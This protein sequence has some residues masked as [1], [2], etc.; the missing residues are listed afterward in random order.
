MIITARAKLIILINDT[1]VYNV[2]TV[3][4]SEY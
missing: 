2:K 4:L 1:K 3:E